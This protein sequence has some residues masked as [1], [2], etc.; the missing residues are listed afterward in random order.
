MPSV[1]ISELREL[2]RRRD[3]QTAY[4]DARGRKQESPVATLKSALD[5]RGP[6][7]LRRIVE[8]VTV[9][10]GRRPL[11]IKLHGEHADKIGWTLIL[12]DGSERAGSLDAAPVITIPERIP[13][14]YHTLKL[15]SG[16]AEAETF[17]IASPSK[18]P[19]PEAKTWGIFLPLYAARTQRNWGVGDLGDLADFRSWIKDLGG[20]IVAT[21]PLLATFADEPSPYS[22]VSRLFWNELYLDVER[23]PEFSPADRHV[24]AIAALRN[25]ERVDYES[26]IREKR[27][28]LERLA[29]RF[30]PDEDFQT[31]AR[32]G[33]YA[34]AHFRAAKEDLDSSSYHLYVQYRMHQQ[35][36]DARRGGLDLDF[37]VGVNRAGF[38]AWKYSRAFVQG[39]SVGLPPDA[40][41]PSGQNWGFAPMDPDAI[42][43][44][45]YDY[46]RAAI[47]HHVTHA[48][49]LRIDHVM[50]LHRLF[51]IPD[52]A[53][54]KDGFYVRYK[55]D[56]LYAIL[57][58]EATRASCA[59]VGEDLG[60]VPAYV[61]RLM[62]RRGLRRMYVV[63]YEIRP[64]DE[65]PLPDPPA[66]AVA[67]VNTHDM[68]PFAT[69]WKE[70]PKARSLLSDS[71]GDT[72]AVLEALLRRLASSSA[73]I[74]LVNLED[75]WLETEPQNVPGNLEKSWTKKLRHTLEEM[76][77]DSDV[78]RVLREVNER[79]RE[80]DG[81]EG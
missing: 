76:R 28:A 34:Y 39:A 65:D 38:D 63:Q 74:V 1:K 79:R 40:A 42:R 58:L 64:D 14:G 48:S 17:V 59:I 10:W 2:A 22:P 8:P 54:A 37:P 61:P 31:W 15:K 53:E 56:E 50:G 4:R 16:G 19:A 45:R 30:V 52:G 11:R 81:N 33:A 51:W 77:S 46:F 43:E 32:R 47:R 12:E 73:E 27:R 69:F 26:V 6:E 71:G 5:L 67:S 21:L 60:T 7:P 66:H 80:V 57:V 18:A 35:M 20:D 68:P 24:T 36:S 29:K 13:H 9:V 49:V 41:F 78:T 3:I 70:N 72:K 23:L 55:E 44:Q 25:M 75:L 62:K